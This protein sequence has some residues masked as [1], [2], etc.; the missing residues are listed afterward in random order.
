MFSPENIHTS[1]I[2]CTQQVIFRNMYGNI[3][4]Y[5]QLLTPD[6]NR[7]WFEVE[8]RGIGINGRVLTEERKEKSN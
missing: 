4:T 7:K 1:Y 6:K 8:Q 5:T 3:N 2:I